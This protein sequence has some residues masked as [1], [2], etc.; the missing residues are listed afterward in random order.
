MSV[1]KRI[2]HW[3]QKRG[4]LTDEGG[5]LVRH[6]Y[7]P[8]N[9][10]VNV[11]EL[12]SMRATAVFAC[13]RLISGTVASLPLPVY[14]KLGRGKERAPD[15][16]MYHILHDRPNEE[17]SSF[18][19]RQLSLAHMLLYG[20]AYSEIEY[21]AGRPVALWPL[22]P[23][24][25]QVSR[26]TRGN[27]F[28]EITDDNGQTEVLPAWKVL[29]FPNITLDGL[30]GMSCIRAGA[31]AIGLSLAAEEFG[32][33]FFGQGANVG[34]IVEYPGK[35]KD[36]A[37]DN[38]KKSVREGYSGLGKSH[39]LMLLEE[40]MK[41]HRVG[42]PPNEAQML[43][44]RKFQVAEIGRL[45]GISQLH[46]IGDLERATFS[47]IEH[48]AIE[49]VV[50]TIR[51]LLVN[52]EQEINYKLFKD[53][54]YFTEFVVD[55]LLRG[56]TQARYQAYATARQWGWMSAN[57][58]RELE[59][60][61]PL[62]DKQGDIYLI[63][64][65]M[66]P[67]D[68]ARIDLPQERQ[69]TDTE[70]RSVR[71][72]MNRSRTAKGY[73]GVFKDAANRIVAREVSNIKKAVKKHISERTLQTFD[74]WLEDFYREYPDYIRRQMA[75]VMMGLVEAIQGIAA[76]EVNAEI[77]MTPEIER[78]ANEYLDTY[79]ARHVIASRAQ[80][81][82]DVTRA[83][84]EGLDVEEEIERRVGYWEENRANEIALDET[85]RLSNAIA[86]TVFASA[87]IERL[88]WHAIGAETCPL[89][90]EMDGKVVGINQPFVAKEDVLDAE[91]VSPLR[92]SKPTRHPGL[93]KGCV[94]V[95]MPE[96]G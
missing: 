13:V 48:Q 54:P 82:H 81:K 74:Q 8:V 44:T 19:W 73:R 25:T 45:F 1:T 26:S 7:N 21:R 18:V 11:T 80:I 36:S 12:S 84:E 96:R 38:Y 66:I 61:N 68:Q 89:C 15:S 77:G 62:P 17:I 59:N 69:N 52:I 10:G 46:K 6:F 35:L 60:Q 41:Y 49:F 40:G 30:K 27:K 16:P 88:R 34:G 94:C 4:L 39:R 85:V 33:R 93:H 2:V 42:I 31:E 28:Y 14:K 67:A 78:F 57:D 22:P 83:T 5:W 9:S 72:A 79:T 63:P 75:P 50:D 51:P 23:W 3:L 65:N 95:V 55:G 32:A 29:H 87:G 37:L 71:A 56:D 47:N 90:Q 70:K 24:K 86:V 43:E 53:K 64:M 76:Q 92:V 91:G 58:I 20:D